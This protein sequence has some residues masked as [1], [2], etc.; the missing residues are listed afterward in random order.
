MSNL[1]M[2]E[3]QAYTSLI[4]RLGLILSML[5]CEEWWVL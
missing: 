4:L 2:E 3:E 1:R 5:A